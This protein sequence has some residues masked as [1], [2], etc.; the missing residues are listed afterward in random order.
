M[1]K[2]DLRTLVLDHCQKC[3]EHAV[4]VGKLHKELHGVYKA[5]SAGE[6]DSKEHHATLANVHQTLV[7]HHA[8]NA[9]QWASFGK[10]LEESPDVLPTPAHEGNRG[11]GG[12]LDGPRKVLGHGDRFA[13]AVDDG[14]R[15]VIPDNKDHQLVR[16]F[17]APS[18]D[19]VDPI[20]GVPDDL[21]KLVRREG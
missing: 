20:A 16:R 10:S 6:G 7:Q 13:R 15:G 8:D 18:V 11:R 2:K 4:A 21:K 3:G 17:G 12:D 19:D 1:A 14:V 5:L 9:A